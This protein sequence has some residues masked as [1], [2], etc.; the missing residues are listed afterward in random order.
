MHKEGKR[1]ATKSCTQA[2]T[3]PSVYLTWNSG[4]PGATFR[5]PGEINILKMGLSIAKL[6]AKSIKT[7]QWYKEDKRLMSKFTLN[8]AINMLCL[9]QLLSVTLA[10]EESTPPSIEL[11]STTIEETKE[12]KPFSDQSMPNSDKNNVENSN[13][14]SVTSFL[15]EHSHKPPPKVKLT[16][17]FDL[18]VNTTTPNSI[19][20]EWRLHPDMERKIIYYRVYYV[21]ESYR[22]V[23]TIK[24]QNQGTY[25]LTGL[26]E[27]S[28]YQIF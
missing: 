9:V 20:L 22:D 11:T 25:E 5:N 6:T 12:I 21:H 24:L 27:C 15:L 19:T 2:T 18:K 10:F 3:R 1:Q 23:K 28:T 16:G 7:R 26:G 14:K 4:Y 13:Q 17:P 8:V